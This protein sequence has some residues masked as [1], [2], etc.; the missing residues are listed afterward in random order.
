MSDRTKKT[1]LGFLV[2]VTILSLVAPLI[3]LTIGE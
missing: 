3:P 1:I 2:I